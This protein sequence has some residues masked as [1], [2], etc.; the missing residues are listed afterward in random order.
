MGRKATAAPL[1]AAQQGGVITENTLQHLAARAAAKIAPHAAPWALAAG[2]GPVAA[3]THALWGSAGALPWASA[4]LALSGAALTGVTWLVSRY[5]HTLGR[6][7]STGTTAVASGWLLAATITGPTSRP[8]LDIGLWLGGTL[9]AAWNIRNVIRM[10][11]DPDETTLGPATGPG[12]LFKRIVTGTAEKA[13]VDI[14]RVRNVQVQPHRVSGTVELGDGQTIEDLQRAVPAMEA[15]GRLPH[16][17]FVATPNMQD[18][19][20]PTLVLSNPLLLEE[21]VLWPGPSR[22]GKTVAD[23][24]RVGLFQDGTDSEIVLAGAHLQVMGMTGS[25]KTTGGAWTI[26][27]ELITRREVAL[28][29]IDITK[30]EQSVGPARPALHR[31]ASTKDQAKKLLADVQ[32]ILAERTDYLAKKHLI[33][34]QPGCGLTYLVLWIEEAADV[35]E[36]IDMDEFTNLARALRS[37]GGSIVW[38]L[39]RADSTQ[40]PTIVK[41]QG[42]AYVCFGVANSH[43]AK[44]GLSD[45]QEDAGAKPERWKNTKPGMAYLDAPGVAPERTAMPARFYD[46]GADDEQRVDNFAAHCAAYP[47]SSRPVD[48]ITARILGGQTAAAGVEAA[49]DDTEDV[50]GV[51]R[52]Y[53]KPDPELDAE[54]AANPVDLD[55]PLQDVEDIPLGEPERMSP[56]DACMVLDRTLAGFGDGRPFAPRDLRG[57]LEATGFSRQWL[58]KQ[59]KARV[60]SGVLVYDPESAEPYRVHV[61]EPA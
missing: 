57:V 26:W 14:A 5:R 8:T 15:A 4:G 35:F 51:T 17:A 22:P 40:M 39:Q 44:W 6:L 1:R 23:P 24:L 42:G 29:V 61:L 19:G 10:A 27:G 20:A 37:A 46:W 34:W 18:A 25:A 49:P 33:K 47:A 13:G 30:G 54:D 58:Q 12:A 28:L 50:S 9:C 32:G 36:H 31:V 48:P 45:E 2:M 16:G 56:E 7:Q 55:A 11:T 21:P 53:L 52:E 3:G 41:G 43:D 60:E 59:L 38:S